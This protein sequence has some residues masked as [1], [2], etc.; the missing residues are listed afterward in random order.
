[1]SFVRAQEGEARQSAASLCRKFV[2]RSRRSGRSDPL[3]SLAVVRSKGLL[4]PQCLVRWKMGRAI[5][6]EGSREKG[7]AWTQ[8]TH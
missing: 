8:E 7:Q 2:R 5:E 3:S 6:R 1:M 4:C